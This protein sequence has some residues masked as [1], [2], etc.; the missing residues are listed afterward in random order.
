MEIISFHKE[1]TKD[2]TNEKLKRIARH[3]LRLRSKHSIAV[4][5]VHRKE[6]DHVHLHVLLS[7]IEY[8]VG[9]SIRISKDDF[10][11]KVKLPMERF[12]ER[13]HP[14]L[15]RSKIN[16]DKVLEKVKKKST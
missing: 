14:D 3:Y 2:L 8:K 13:F 1:N 9:R 7:G 11:N 15:E 16:H 10:K 6:K 5:T 12:Q 4:V